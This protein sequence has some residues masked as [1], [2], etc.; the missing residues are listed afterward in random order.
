[1]LS[2]IFCK[3]IITA[4]PSIEYNDFIELIAGKRRMTRNSGNKFTFRNTQEKDKG[5]E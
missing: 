5:G 1:M 2:T 4:R 3:L